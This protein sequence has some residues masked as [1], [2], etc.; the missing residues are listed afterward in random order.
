MKKYINKIICADSASFLSKLKD[1]SVDI[2]L[3]DP[4]YFLDKMDHNWSAKKVSGPKKPYA[5]KH[6]PAGM[7]F[8]KEQGKEFYSWYLKISTE[9]FRIL[10]PGGFF[11][12]FSSPRLYHRMASAMD[13]AGFEIR[14]CFIWLYTQNQA[15]AMSLHHFINKM[16]KPAKEKEKLNKQFKNWKTPQVKSCHEPIAMAQKPLEGTYIEN[17]IK[18]NISLINTNIRQGL[19]K[20]MFVSNI[21][22][23][24]LIHH[25]IDKVFLVDKPKER[26]KGT[27]NNHKTVKPL[28]LFKYLINLT[29]KKNSIVLDPFMGSGTTAVACSELGRKF[30]G[31]EVN[32]QY[33][34]IANKRLKNVVKTK[35]REKQ[36]LILEQQEFAFKEYSLF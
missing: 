12:S 8:T 5:I 26:E 9:L 14:D 27:F 4:P 6:L 15:K 29:T 1:K 10:K 25:R 24:T 32:K 33:I 21:M 28:S 20:D 18:H 31:V 30:V 36:P 7:K 13:D 11:F 17:S 2:V 35:P 23:H 34:D 3:T 22:T 16:D 19:Y